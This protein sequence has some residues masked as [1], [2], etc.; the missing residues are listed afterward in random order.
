MYAR[1]FI[2]MINDTA[3]VA[4]DV[5]ENECF[6]A[7]MSEQLPRNHISL[8]SQKNQLFIM[9]GLFVDEENKD[10]PLQCYVYL[11]TIFFLSLFLSF[12]S[13]NCTRI[14]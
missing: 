8:V 4:Y 12:T 9:G 3:A 14:A 1:Q 11:V 5:N 7:A 2:L 10:V 13:F 6:L